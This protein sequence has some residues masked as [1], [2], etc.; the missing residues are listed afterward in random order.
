MPTLFAKTPKYGLPYIQGSDFAK[1]IPEQSKE[2]AETLEK[3]IGNG[4]FKG[5]KGDRGLPGLNAVPTDTAMAS[6]VGD[7][8]TQTRAALDAWW[9]S[10][11]KASGSV[12]NVKDYGAKG[13]GVTDDWDAITAAITAAGNATTG[14]VVYFPSGL[15]RVRRAISVPSYR[16]LEGAGMGKTTIKL[17]DNAPEDTFVITNSGHTI[18]GAGAKNTHITI[19]DMT[20]DWNFARGAQPSESGSGGTRSSALCIAYC[21]FVQI[22]RV[23]TV[24]SKL[25]GIDITSQ[26][27]ANTEAAFWWLFYNYPGDMYEDNSPG[28]SR[29]IWVEDCDTSGFGDDGITTHHSEF[30]WIRGCYSHDPRNRDNNNGIEIDDGSRSVFLES[31]MSARCYAG[32]E[33]KAHENSPAAQRGFISGHSSYQACRSYNWRHIGHH[34]GSDPVSKSARTISATNLV[35]FQPKNAGGFQDEAACRALAISAFSDVTVNGFTAIGDNTGFGVDDSVI[36]LQYRATQVNLSNVTI[37]SFEGAGRDIYITGGDNRANWINL[38]NIIIRASTAVGISCGTDV[39]RVNM[40]NIILNGPGGSSSVGIN[41]I[42]TGNNIFGVRS[43]GYATALRN[44]SSYYTSD[45][46]VFAAPLA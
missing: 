23:R 32:I 7:G 41:C 13:D 43:T 10:H 29:W 22:K 16:W 1:D 15:Y 11:G 18:T 28:P 38:S 12:V 25:H 39:N 31:N 44:G 2:I 36:V 4:T 37:R 27:S 20:L 34:T 5:D 35:A 6:Y 40:S 14:H 9:D 46:T 17:T 45:R 3:L 21:E 42:S 26:G 24:N 8:G 33:I 19:Q 30:I